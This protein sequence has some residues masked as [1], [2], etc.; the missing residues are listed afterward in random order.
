MTK[1]APS[2][3]T[4][5]SAGAP[6]PG[7]LMV[8]DEA[9]DG[10]IAQGGWQS[11]DTRRIVP[12][13]RIL[14]HLRVLGWALAPDAGPQAPW[15]AITAALN[16]A[17]ALG[18][19]HTGRGDDRRF[20]PVEVLNFL[21]WS[22]LAGLH[23]AWRTALIPTAR[24]IACD[25]M[26]EGDWLR[27]IALSRRFNP[28]RLP[29]NRRVRLRMPVPITHGG[30]YPQT[31][32]VMPD[33]VAEARLAADS[34]RI[35]AVLPLPWHGPDAPGLHARFALTLS[36]DAAR[37][38]PAPDRH[39]ARH[40]GFV[41]VTPT[42]ER[43]AA[44]LVGSEQDP[45]RVARLLRDHLLDR[46]WLGAVHYGALTDGRPAGDHVLETGWYDCQLG[47]A[48]LVALCR[49]RGIPARLVSGYFLHPASLTMHHWAEVWDD[50]S[51]WLGF[52]LMVWDLSAA[53]H[54][55]RWRDHFAG[56]LTPRLITARLPEAFT[57]APG[58]TMPADWFTLLDSREGAT[59][60]ALCCAQ[61]GEM[62]FTDR[63][64]V[65]E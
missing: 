44:D 55:A 28:D 20:D 7:S 40:D 9:P 27:T 41:T 43:L 65:V 52:D 42:V 59:F 30:Q 46:L 5:A 26:A 24:A 14:A 50:R 63:L 2:L 60:T 18:L 3:S 54:D 61:T 45:A 51:G 11:D 47:A 15:H 29:A 22:G 8:P 17:I 53:G 57:G 12:E 25:G 19:P 39:L 31:I 35:E 36:G 10:R 38:T 33:S 48:L 64:Q 37:D 56:S 16:V 58:P 4:T 34:S 62:V 23:P 1:A 13:A 32:T 49:A 6:A 21:K